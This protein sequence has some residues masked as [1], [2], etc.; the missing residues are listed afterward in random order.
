MIKTSDI[1]E[2]MIE[3]TSNC[4]AMCL[5]CGRNL[6]GVKL[7]PNLK[8]GTEGN[9]KFETFKNVFNRSV[10]PNIGK[11]HFDGNFGDS[12]IHPESMKFVKYIAQEFPGIEFEVNTNGGYH[13][14]D[15]WHELGKITST[16]FSNKDQVKFGI[17]GIDNETH[18]KYRRNVKFD[19]VIENAKAFISGGGTPVWKFLEFEHN[20]DQIEQAKR[21]AKDLGFHKFSIK[22][23][24]WREKA[25]RKITGKEQV[26]TGAASKKHKAVAYKTIPKS[27][28][29]IVKKIEKQLKSFKD[30]TNDCEIVCEWSTRNRVQIEYDGRVWQCCHLSGRYGS[31][32]GF[33]MKDYQYYVDKHGTDWNNINN[34]SLQ[35]I[36]E[37]P[38]WNDLHDS[39]NNKTT[40][41]NN[42]RIRRCAEK[43]GKGVDTVKSENT[44]L[45]KELV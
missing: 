37:H 20:T 3:I 18:D 10:L 28:E 23:T 32:T 15:Y 9:M 16:S 13:D 42:P 22:K 27:E 14:T 45:R 39:F 36:F 11:I 5:D 34:K 6:D 17:D 26:I 4:Q 21:L 24:R 38:Y 1:D 12:L 41:N 8:F 2:I 35:E 29:A 44:D 19:K 30:F 33:A 40:D 25:I 7:N 31:G 43:C